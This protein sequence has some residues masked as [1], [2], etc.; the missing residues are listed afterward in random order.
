MLQ[1]WA[2]TTRRLIPRQQPPPILPAS[3]PR[4]RPYDLASPAA[5]SAVSAD[6]RPVVQTPPQPPTKQGS[7]AGG[8][9]TASEWAHGS[10]ADE[11]EEHFASSERPTIIAPHKDLGFRVRQTGTASPLA[12]GAAPRRP[13]QADEAANASYRLILSYLRDKKKMGVLPPEAKLRDQQFEAF[14]MQHLVKL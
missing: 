5:G 10:P 1:E 12:R 3:C 4:R 13:S 7:P 6:Q 11:L 14:V 8:E 9:A 2:A